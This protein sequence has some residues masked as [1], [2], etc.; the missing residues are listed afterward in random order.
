MKGSW[1]LDG[2]NIFRESHVIQDITSCCQQTN[3]RKMEESPQHDWCQN[4]AQHFAG[5]YFNILATCPQDVHKFYQESS[6]RSQLRC[7][8]EEP[9]NQGPTNVK[10][11]GLQADGCSNI[12]EMVMELV[13]K[14]TSA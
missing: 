10:T 3:F 2:E 8:E 12:Q 5:F 1:P 9:A 11:E 13:S 6:T 4:F 7:Y 14:G